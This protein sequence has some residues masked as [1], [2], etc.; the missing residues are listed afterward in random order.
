MI[1][2]GCGECKYCWPIGK[3]GERIY[4]TPRERECGE[5]FAGYRDKECGLVEAISVGNLRKLLEGLDDSILVDVWFHKSLLFLGKDEFF[6]TGTLDELYTWKRYEDFTEQEKKEFREMFL[7]RN[8]IKESKKVEIKTLPK[9]HAVLDS[10]E[11][12]PLTQEEFDADPDLPAYLDPRYNLTEEE[13]Q[14][15]LD[16]ILSREEQEDLLR[17]FSESRKGK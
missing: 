7:Q 3:E 13:S 11:D 5:H 2:E 15:Y 4:C 12:K 9:A 6:G 17:Q 1:W 14:E 16:S 8:P 10:N